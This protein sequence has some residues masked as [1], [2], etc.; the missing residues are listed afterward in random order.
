MEC[1][2]QNK[3]LIN[4]SIAVVLSLLLLSVRRQN[5]PLRESMQRAELEVLSVGGL[6]SKEL[7]WCLASAN[8]G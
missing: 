1:V 5:L 6:R 8:S 4:K 3:C 7:M 2:A